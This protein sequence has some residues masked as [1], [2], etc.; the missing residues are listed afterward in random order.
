[1]TLV[2]PNQTDKVFITW[3]QGYLSGVNSMMEITKDGLFL[4][5]HAKPPEE[6]Q[7]YLRE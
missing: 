1:L 2:A 3:A 4:D 5:L 7:R 6:M